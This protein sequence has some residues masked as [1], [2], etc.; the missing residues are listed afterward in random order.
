MAGDTIQE[1]GTDGRRY[2]IRDGT[3]GRRYD[4]QTC[5]LM[6]GDTI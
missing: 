2:D 4:I 6:A 3:D 5:E 1:I